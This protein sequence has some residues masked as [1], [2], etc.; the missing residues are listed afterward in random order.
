MISSVDDNN[1][2]AEWVSSKGLFSEWPTCREVFLEKLFEDSPNVVALPILACQVVGGSIAAAV[3]VAAAW[4]MLRYAADLFDAVQDGDH[5]P[6]NVNDPPSAIEFANGLIFSAFNALATIHAENVVYRLVGSFSDLAFRAS[7]GQN[8]SHQYR[9]K[10]NATLEAYWQA[11]ILKSGSIFHAGLGGGAI[12]GQA[13]PE[14]YTALRKFGNALGVIRQ[15]ID[16]CRDMFD[17]SNTD[18]YEITLPLLL[19]S[20]KLGEPIPLLVRRLETKEALSKTLNVQGVPDMITS[21]L[22][23]WHRRAEE[24]LLVLEQSSEV[25]ALEVIL[26]EFVS[27]LGLK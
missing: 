13:A 20:E 5:L 4:S 1:M 11:T 7:Q 14:S 26:Q 10:D 27:K 19:L 8:L 22:M 9:Q 16:D 25:Q 6:K 2:L 12:V 23:E 24:N 3:P 18:T 21:V 15:V 17:D